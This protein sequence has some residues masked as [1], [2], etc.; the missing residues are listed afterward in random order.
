M[1]HVVLLRDSIFDNGQYTG[2]GPDVAWQL[3][4][5]L[6]GWGD[7]CPPYG[8]RLIR[9]ASQLLRQFVQP[10]RHSVPFDVLKRLAIYAGCSAIGFAAFVGENQNVLSVHLVVQSIE[11]KVGRSLR[12][13]V[14]RRLQLLNAW[15]SC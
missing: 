7:R 9:S 1:P 15:G 12:F 6:S 8:L 10:L 11:A 5:L 14:Q 2:G 3:R 4:K 13:V